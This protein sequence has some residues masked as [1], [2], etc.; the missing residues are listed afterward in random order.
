MDRPG[1]LRTDQPR[2]LHGRADQPHP[3]LRR[4][5]RARRHSASSRS[6]T[7]RSARTRCTD[8]AAR[9]ASSTARCSPT[10]SA[11]TCG[12]H[13]QLALAFDDATKRELK[14]WYDA[15]VESDRVAMKVARGE[16]LSQFDA[17]GR[18]LVHGGRVP[19]GARERD[20]VARVDARVQPARRSRLSLMQNPDIMQDRDGVLR[21]AG[22]AGAGAGAGPASRRVP[23]GHPL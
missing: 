12:D 13:A 3:P 16:E 6:A 20:G 17:F 1:R 19:G 10:R 4:R 8:A 11:R 22:R 21:E 14:P 9:S 2:P 7:R 18:S 5:R 15:S 23:Q